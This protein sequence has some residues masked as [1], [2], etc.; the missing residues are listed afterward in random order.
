MRKSINSSGARSSFWMRKNWNLTSNQP[1]TLPCV[2]SFFHPLHLFAIFNV[3]H[4]TRQ[5][6]LFLCT[7]KNDPHTLHGIVRH[8]RQGSTT[9]CPWA[10]LLCVSWKLSLN[11]HFSR[12]FQSSKK[13]FSCCHSLS[14]PEH[15]KNWVQ[16]AALNLVHFTFIFYRS[17]ISF[18]VSCRA[19]ESE[20]EKIG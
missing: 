18:F 15:A 19:S 12:D 3:N 7:M 8:A 11:S 20:R 9:E 17:E 1:S 6:N 13:E 5:R 4:S 16:N 2:I 14:S 10:F